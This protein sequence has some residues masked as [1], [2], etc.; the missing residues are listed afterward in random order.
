MLDYFL[1]HTHVFEFITHSPPEPDV[2]VLFCVS[3]PVIE[4][5]LT[6]LCCTSRRE[7]EF[8]RRTAAYANQEVQSGTDREVTASD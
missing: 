5:D 1:V 2:P 7:R 4:F 3:Y 6:G 8:A